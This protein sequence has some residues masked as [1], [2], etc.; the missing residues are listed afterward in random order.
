MIVISFHFLLQSPE[1]YLPFGCN[2]IV[3]RANFW[4]PYMV[5]EGAESPSWKFKKAT[6]LGH[7]GAGSDCWEAQISPCGVTLCSGNLT[8]KCWIPMQKTKFI[9]DCNN[10]LT[11][12][13]AATL[14]LLEESF[15]VWINFTAATRGPGGQRCATRW[16]WFSSSFHCWTIC[17]IYQRWFRIAFQLYMYIHTC[18]N[19]CRLEK[20]SKFYSSSSGSEKKHF[21]LW[22]RRVNESTIC[23]SPM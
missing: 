18:L 9:V 21:V 13:W 4:C 7:S 10:V 2:L 5:W 8:K 11:I 6:N 20:S 16:L 1:F 3:S 19:K 23:L 17:I 14:S 15:T 12:T 22:N